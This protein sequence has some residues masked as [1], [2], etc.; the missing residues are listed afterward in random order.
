MNLYINHFSA[1]AKLGSKGTF[2]EENFIIRGVLLSD[3]EVPTKFSAISMEDLKNLKGLDLLKP[4]EKS[5]KEKVLLFLR[6]EGKHDLHTEVIGVVI[7][8]FQF[9]QVITSRRSEDDDFEKLLNEKVIIHA[10]V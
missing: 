10:V 6:S 7:Q 2:P 4:F 3:R 1:T 9:S 5:L 8:N